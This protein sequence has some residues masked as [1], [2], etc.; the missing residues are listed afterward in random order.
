MRNKVIICLVGSLLVISF[1]CSSLTPLV[2]KVNLFEGDNVAKAVAKI[3]EKV[4]AATF[5]VAT[6]DIYPNKMSVELQSPKNA[7]DTDKYT[8]E[9]GGVTGPEPVQTTKYAPES[10]DS[11]DWTVVPS[12]VQQSIAASK[13]EGGSVTHMTLDLQQ[14]YNAHP[15]LRDVADPE[16]DAKRKACTPRRTR[17]AAYTF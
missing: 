2:S 13:L 8:F 17:P 7:K 14:P 5:N 6:V 12:I 1:G 9:N 4:G 11:V 10:I 3:K 15:E 16:K